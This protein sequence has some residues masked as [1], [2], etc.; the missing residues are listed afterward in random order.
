M[1]FIK[2]VSYLPEVCFGFYGQ[3]CEFN[4]NIDINE[5]ENVASITESF[6]N[7]IGRAGEKQNVRS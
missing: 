4:M 5:P 1:C 3:I 7:K 6:W 2:L